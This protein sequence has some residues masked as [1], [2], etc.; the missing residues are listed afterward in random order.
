MQ[1]SGKKMGSLKAVKDS[2]KKGGSSLNTFIKNV[3]ADG[4]TVRFITEPEEWFG[5]YEYWNDESRNFTPMAVGEILPDGARPSFRY[6]ASAVDIETDRVIPLKLAKTAANSLILKYDKYGTMLDRNYELQR[7]GEGLDTT[8]DVT[9]DAPSKLNLAKYE[10][11]DLEQVLI[12]ARATSLGE[13]DTK[14]STPTIDDDE[15]DEEKVVVT[16]G[17]KSPMV[18]KKKFSSDDLFPNG[19]YREDYSQEEL[20]FMVEEDATA[21][22][23]I[24]DSWELSPALKGEKAISAILEAQSP[25]SKDD[26]DDE[27]IDMDEETSEPEVLDEE[28]LTAMSLRDLRVICEDYDIDHEGMNKPAM[29]RSIIEASEK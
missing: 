21:I 12:S 16:S 2:L 7:H 26:E 1:I 27:I 24:L 13:T 25:S 17:R 23:D 28:T 3:P 20:E 8:Y 9:P 19:E 5:F 15:L 22:K 10:V 29:I 14:A 6:L 18:K 11:I 4:I